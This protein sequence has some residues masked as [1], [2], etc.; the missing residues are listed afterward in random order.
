[1]AGDGNQSVCTP[2]SADNIKLLA[3]SSTFANIDKPSGSGAFVLSGAL[4]DGST[5]T[6]RGLVVFSI[7]GSFLSLGNLELEFSSERRTL[8]TGGNLGGQLTEA[9]TINFL[10]SGSDGSGLPSFSSVSLPA[11]GSFILDPAIISS[12]NTITNV[13]VLASFIRGLITAIAPRLAIRN[14]PRG[15]A[16]GADAS[17]GVIGIGVRYFNNEGVSGVLEY[18]TIVGRE[19]IDQHS[20]NLLLRADFD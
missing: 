8:V 7:D 16:A 17:G 1:M 20:L 14:N 3:V 19:N 11:S 2:G 10:A 15:G 12:S 5:F 9:G 18:S 4:E 6:A 13:I